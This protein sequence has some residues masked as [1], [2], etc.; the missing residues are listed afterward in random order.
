MQVGASPNKA[1]ELQHRH[2]QGTMA[3]NSFV[4]GLGPG[5]HKLME[6]LQCVCVCVCVCACEYMELFRH[7]L[8][9]APV[10]NGGGSRECNLP[11]RQS[12]ST[13]VPD[14][15]PRPLCKPGRGMFPQH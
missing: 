10:L 13:P 4:R 3:V 15:L 9:E 8:P 14:L 2:M 1:D 5:P 11:G 7:S 6:R 12:L